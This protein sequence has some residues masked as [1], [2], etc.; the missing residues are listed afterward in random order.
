[1]HPYLD[2]DYSFLRPPGKLLKE[3]GQDEIFGSNGDRKIYYEIKALDKEISA[4]EE[5]K[6]KWDETMQKRP[7]E[8]RLEIPNWWVQGDFLRYV[9]T[10]ELNVNSMIKQVEIHLKWLKSLKNFN[11]SPMAA[12]FLVN[13]NVYI[14]G[15]DKRGI[16]CMVFTTRGLKKIDK[17]VA[18]E[19][20]KSLTFCLLIIKKYMLVPKYIEK[21]HFFMDLNNSSMK[22][23]I[24]LIKGQISLFQDNYNGFAGNCYIYKPS[25]TFRILWK[26]IEV[27]VPK[28]TL[29]RVKFVENGKERDF[30]EGQDFDDLQE[31]YG[32]NLPNIEENFWP[33]R[34]K[35][36][37]KGMTTEY[38]EE[39]NIKEFL[40]TG[41]ED[42]L[43]LRGDLRGS[44]RVNK[45]NFSDNSFL[46]SKSGKMN[47]N[48]K[49]S[50]VSKPV[51]QSFWDKFMCCYG[52]DKQFRND[53][54]EEIDK[55][56]QN[57]IGRMREQKSA[58]SKN[59]NNSCVEILPKNYKNDLKYKSILKNDE[60]KKLGIPKG[61]T[62][63][64]NQIDDNGS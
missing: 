33:P 34:A 1:M 44:I 13:G 18:I 5:F 47:I 46:T 38:M 49:E 36:G 52:K 55:S 7:E 57:S 19:L 59:S 54:A 11:L 63:N 41:P 51:K 26:I 32:G 45:L 28:K 17:T 10:N 6:I 3:P 12:E 21:Y 27:F 60:N 37:T 29:E 50:D 64:T 31:R 62:L 16:P 35:I 56:V 58:N 2:I 8:E 30:A 20:T 9:C 23:Q 53:N 42:H 40:A 43:I 48:R 24:D 4:I 14:A 61:V 39:N 15:R 22:P 25:F